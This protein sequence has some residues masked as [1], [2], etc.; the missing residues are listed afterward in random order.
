MRYYITD[1]SMKT[2]EDANI[3]N[4]V[5]FFRRYIKRECEVGDCDSDGCDTYYAGF[6]SGKY[7][8]M[9]HS[10]GWVRYFS[11]DRYVD[12]EYYI[13]EISKEEATKNGVISDRDWVRV[14]SFGHDPFQRLGF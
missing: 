10:W 5:E 2:W 3:S 7:F 12:N 14:A 8:K 1:V 4:E 11:E 13:V 6:S 9:D